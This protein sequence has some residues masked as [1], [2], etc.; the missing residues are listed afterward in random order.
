MWLG[1]VDRELH[2][3][4]TIDDCRAIGPKAGGA[5]H[6]DR[7]VARAAGLEVLKNPAVGQ[8]A[9]PA[10]PA[11]TALASNL[12]E[13]LTGT[14][15]AAISH[16][17]SNAQVGRVVPEGVTILR[18]PTDLPEWRHRALFIRDPEGNVIEIYAEH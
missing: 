8:V 16:P 17:E 18:E 4:S 11:S 5:N 13:L 14:Q 2:Q 12:A 1:R 6:N 10:P 9:V 3:G 15:L 7:R